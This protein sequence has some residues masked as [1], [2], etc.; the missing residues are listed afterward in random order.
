MHRLLL[1]L[2]LLA[3]PLFAE[4]STKVKPPAGTPDAKL[5]QVQISA[6]WVAYPPARVEAAL[7]ASPTA[8]LGQAE[9]RK[10]FAE[11]EK[12]I[13]HTQTVVTLSGINAVAESVEEIIYPTEFDISEDQD[14][15][16]LSEMGPYNSKIIVAP[17]HIPGAF[18]TRE[19]GAIFNATPTV[20]AD[21]ET[22]NLQLLPE[23]TELERW[24]EY[25][26]DVSL[27]LPE[28]P[29]VHMPQP[30]FR[31]HNVTTSLSLKS[32]ATLALSG[33]RDPKTREYVYLYVNAVILNT[34]GQPVR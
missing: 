18:E 31:H 24:I 34:E 11:G 12:R 14:M 7:S 22:I 19:V 1:S 5:R 23:I 15:G 3:D 16:A 30:V 29:P 17:L 13:L 9:L 10:L 20:N 32:G 21:N 2:L 27:P 4:E 6:T 28:T 25:G 33:G 26:R 8:V